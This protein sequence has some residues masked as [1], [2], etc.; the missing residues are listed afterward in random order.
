MVKP[1]S[2]YEK[3]M[4]LLRA[5]VPQLFSHPGSLLYVGACE[6]RCH[7]TKELQASGNVLTALEV[8]EPFVEKLRAH[9]V[10]SKRFKF[11][12]QGDV[13]KIDEM[14]KYAG[15]CDYSFWWHGPEHVGA[16]EMG[17]ALKN[18]EAM[19]TKTVVLASPWGRF[20]EGAVHGNPHNSHRW[21][22]YPEHLMAF[23]YEVAALGP[24][25]RPGGQVLA[26]KNVKEK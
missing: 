13:T 20:P 8:W 6:R 22:I 15:G 26:W 14:P 11:I 10:F 5:M 1:R 25:N 18:L 19:T 9:P 12:V 16:H 23:G 7:C 21:Y 17:Q 2:V 24:M 3:R 4:A